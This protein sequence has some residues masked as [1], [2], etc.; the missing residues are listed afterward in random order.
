[1]A[2]PEPGGGACGVS[3][4]GCRGGAGWGGE[5]PAGATTRLVV[6]RRAAGGTALVLLAAEGA[7]SVY[8]G[9]T[10]QRV[11]PIFPPG[12]KV[13]F[14]TPE[15]SYTAEANSMGFRDH[16]VKAKAGFRIVALG[17]SFTYGWGV[18]L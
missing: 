9:M 13:S 1:M 18:E 8:L 17:D 10:S 15:F 11:V 7:A 3:F 2:N 6:T 14:R 16:E 4:G 12:S 5:R